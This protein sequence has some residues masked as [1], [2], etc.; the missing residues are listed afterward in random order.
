MRGRGGGP[1][2]M[3]PDGGSSEVEQEMMMRARRRFPLLQ[4][5][6]RGSRGGALQQVMLLGGGVRVERQSRGV[7]FRLRRFRSRGRFGCGERERGGQ[8]EHDRR[9]REEDGERAPLHETTQRV[10]PARPRGKRSFSRGDG[11]P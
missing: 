6:F 11:G 2:Q 7:V 3:R 5:V 8:A 10:I 4:M 9:E 1:E